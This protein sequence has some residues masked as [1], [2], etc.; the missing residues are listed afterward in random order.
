M[1]SPSERQAIRKWNRILA[2]YKQPHLGRSLFQ[3]VNTAVPFAV[4]WY[5]MLRS[6]EVS[7][8][9][10]LA[11]AL[12]AAA[13][14]IRLF[15]I[16][17][18][19][20]HGA[21]LR[22]PAASRALGYVLGVMTLIP[23]GYWRKTHAIHHATSGNLDEREFGDV[24]TLTVAEYRGL[25]PFRRFLYRLYRNP[26][27]LLGIG[28]FYQ[29]VLKHRFPFD[30]PFSWKKEW[31]SVLWTNLGLAAVVALA[32]RTIGIE[33]FLLVQAPI[34]LLTGSIGVWL[35]YVQHQFEG[36]YW[37]EG[38][39]WSFVRAGLEGSSFYDLPAWLHW[40]TGY[41]GYHHIHHLSSR[42]PNY[43]LARCHRENPELHH[44]KHL[45]MRES[46]GCLRLKLWD[47]ESGRL[48]GFDE[49]ESLPEPAAAPPQGDEAPS[50]TSAEAA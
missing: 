20:G 48:V 47:A 28:P 43:Y 42:V 30:L 6:L 50:A 33:R 36:T 17:H 2:P 5:L 15:I 10:T 37:S 19:L 8:L 22:S 23:Y 32:W 46:L 34:T 40:A 44:A 29:F 27:V 49:V 9:L 18:D 24:T 21:F 35:F 16:Q 3:V 1:T 11:L 14:M 39:E 26:V 4:V 31:A 38:E 12:P 13:L 41:I 7:Y 25:S 45:S